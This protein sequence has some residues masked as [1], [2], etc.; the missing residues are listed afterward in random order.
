VAGPRSHGMFRPQQPAHAAG[1]APSVGVFPSMPQGGVQVQ[2]RSQQQ[3][4]LSASHSATPGAGTGNAKAG[5]RPSNPSVEHSPAH[6]NPNPNP[7]FGTPV[8]GGAPGGNASIS[9]NV[10]AS[11]RPSLGHG[12]AAPGGFGVGD[13]VHTNA[14]SATGAAIPEIVDMESEKEVSAVRRSVSPSPRGGSRGWVEF[15]LQCMNAFLSA[16]ISVTLV[17]VVVLFVLLYGHL[18][19]P[20]LAPLLL[21][22]AGCYQSVLQ[23]AVQALGGVGSRP[24]VDVSLLLE[25]DL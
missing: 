13:A 16:L 15:I 19:A 14:I 25:H 8:V 11:R 5:R 17:I 4:P 18:V 2:G 20:L 22:C 12:N 7:A 21:A 10:S 6:P 23:H 1:P 24:S 3:T 9:A